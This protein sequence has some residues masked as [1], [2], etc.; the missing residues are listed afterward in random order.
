MWS[1]VLYNLG[2]KH[3]PTASFVFHRNARGYRILDKGTKYAAIF[4]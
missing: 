1:N 3:Q 2:F 4:E